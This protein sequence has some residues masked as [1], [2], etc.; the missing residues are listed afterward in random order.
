M[1]A[2]D[3]EQPRSLIL[4]VHGFGGSA[5]DAI[6]S[7]IAEEMGL[8]CSA[9]VRFDFPAHGESPMGNEAFTLQNCMD[10]LMAAAVYAKE[11]FPQVQDH[12]L[13]ATGFGAYVTLLC[14]PRLQA[15]AGRVRLVLQTPAISMHDT[16]LSMLRVSRQTLW[17]MEKYTLPLPRPLD[18]TYGF[19][20]SLQQNSAMVATSQPM[21]ILHGERDEFIHRED[22]H[23]FLQLNENAK[24]V[25]L[26]GIGHRFMEDGAW[27]MVLDLTRDWFEFEQVLLCDCE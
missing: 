13:F 11:Q 15:L 5:K 16:L 25:V 9:T 1:T 8:F 10:A 7:S 19:Y 24:L 14:L 21:L 27:D 26:P 22:L 23:H 2:P 4:G 12:C 20:E 3:P 17:V 18:V 6:Q